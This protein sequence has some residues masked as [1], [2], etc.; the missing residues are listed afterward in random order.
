MEKLARYT[1]L[2]QKCCLIFCP[3]YIRYV[4]YELDGDTT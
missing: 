4:V 2:V 3:I 1:F